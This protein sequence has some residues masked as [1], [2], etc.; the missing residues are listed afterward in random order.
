ME[1]KTF[2]SETLKHI[3]DGV[4]DAQ[5]YVEYTQLSM[6][7][8]PKG[9]SSVP[10][11]STSN[12]IYTDYGLAAVVDFDI[13]VTTTETGSAEGG[14]GIFVGAFSLGARTGMESS[15]N[16][17]SRIKISIPVFLPRQALK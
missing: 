2:I 11:S 10:S 12:F 7:I 15:S 4:D 3:I 17:I 9:G 1:L 5:R 16:S 8:N 14:A 6:A 13:A